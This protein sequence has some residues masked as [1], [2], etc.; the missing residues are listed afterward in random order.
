[1][2]SSLTEKLKKIEYFILDID[3]VMTDGTIGCLETGEMYRTFH[4][5]DGYAI[6]RA[7]NAGYK[8]CVITGG[9]QLGVQKRLEYLKIKD[10]FMGSGGK[11][12]MNIYLEYINTKKID[13]QKVLYMGDDIP[14]IDIMKREQLLAI[15][16]A[17]ATSEIL[18]ISDIITT[19]K[20]GH[21]A[22]REA[23]EMVM[24]SQGNW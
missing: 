10:F 3:G 7:I 9:N 4:V 19:K 16:P 1:M 12:K 13:E 21:G 24:K 2:D 18:E 14:D 23:I 17:N 5:R 20:G 15:A 8:F 22:V 6:E 11:N